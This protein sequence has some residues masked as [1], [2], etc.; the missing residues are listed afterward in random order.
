MVHKPTRSAA[1]LDLIF[2]T[3]PDSITEIEVL[4]ALASDHNIVFAEFLLLATLRCLTPKVVHNSNKLNMSFV[5]ESFEEFLATYGPLFIKNTVESNRNAFKYFFNKL[6]Y[7]FVPTFVLRCNDSNPWFTNKLKCTQNK[8]K[9]FFAK[10][11]RT[12]N[13]EDW[14]KYNECSKTYKSEI[15]NAK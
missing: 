10:A 3:V 4:G 1:I 14:I 7:D 8:K 2:T 11:R 15:K 9:R 6:I 13:G 5:N 12:Q